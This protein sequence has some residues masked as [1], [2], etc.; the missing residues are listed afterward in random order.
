MYPAEARNEN[1]ISTWFLKKIRVILVARQENKGFHL[2][3]N[4]ILEGEEGLLSKNL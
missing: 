3:I 4:I 2:A 1:K